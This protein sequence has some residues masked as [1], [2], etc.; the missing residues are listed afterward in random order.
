MIIKL[1]V[2]LFS[3]TD[4]E[5]DEDTVIKMKHGNVSDI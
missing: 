1:A 2:L 3:L 4:L 5:I